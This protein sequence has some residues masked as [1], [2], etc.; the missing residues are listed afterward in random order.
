VINYPKC[1]GEEISK[2]EKNSRQLYKCKIYIYYYSVIKNP[3]VK[4][5]QKCL[6]LAMYLEGFGF[7]SIRRILKISCPIFFIESNFGMINL[8]L[9][10]KV[11]TK[12]KW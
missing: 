10:K 11:K 1:S 6:V 3:D 12:L 9:F 8:K 2:A 7:R 4:K 5:E